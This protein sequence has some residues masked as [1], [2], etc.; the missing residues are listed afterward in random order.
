MAKVA[1]KYYTVAPWAII[2]EGFDP[3]RGEVSE[4]IFSLSNE[5][6]GVR[7]YFEEGYSGKALIGSYF[8]GI[9][10]ETGTG[11]SSYYRGLALTA[12][13]MVNSVDW[14]YTRIRIDEE[15][16]D[17][18]KCNIASFVRKLDLKTGTLNREYIW[19]TKSGKSIK[20]TFQRF[21][22][23]TAQNIGCQ[24]IVFEPLNFTGEIE[25][26]SG[27]DFTPG[28]MTVEGRNFW[29][30][31]KKVTQGNRAAI[32][33]ETV[34]TGQHVFS[35]FYLHSSEAITPQPVEDEKYVGLKFTLAVVEG[36]KISVEKIIFNHADKSLNADAEE[37][38]DMGMRLSS[39]IEN[40]NFDRALIAHSEYWSKVWDTLDIT[41]EGDEE[42]QQGIRYCIFQLHQTYHGQDASNNVG[43]KGLTGEVYSGHTFWDTETYCLP[44]Y[45]F[46][47][48]VAARNLLGYRYKTLPQAIEWAKLQ[49]CEGAQYP[50]STIDGTESCGTWW[51]G[52]L[53]IHVSAAVSYGIWNYVHVTGDKAFLFEQGIEMLIQ[54]SRFFYSRGNWAPQ[55]GFGLYGVMGAD[56]YHTM[57]SNNCYTNVMAK[58]TFEY[59]LRAIADM[60][61]A[62]PERLQELFKKVLMKAEEQQNWHDAAEKMII[63][64]DKKTGL[65]EQHNGFFGLPHIDVDAIPTNQFPLIKHWAMPRIYRYDMIKQPDVLLFLFFYSQDYTIGEKRANYEYYEPKCI[66]ESSLSPSI[67]SIIASEIGEHEQARDFSL[68]STRLDLDNYNRNT[69][70]GLHTTSIAAAWMNIVYGF[71]GMRSDG[72]MLVFNPSIP[73]MWNGFSF[74]VLYRGATIKVQVTKERAE[75]S[76]ISGPELQVKIFNAIY[77]VGGETLC[78][79]LPDDRKG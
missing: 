54:I 61:Q 36:N 34:K 69:S 73:S 41:I 55:G 21:A 10:E 11:N 7:G 23:M 9:L 19:T 48:P 62:E 6:M 16:L 70:E 43:A 25:V 4:S 49:D 60:Q 35:S 63:L 14:L 56:E 58:K 38:W 26:L 37:V 30:C 5:Y 28:H 24:R 33:G 3:S 64:F 53:E 42:N 22:S 32:L 1:D 45:L 17:I 66:H 79:M 8:N 13:F 52:N 40:L 68:Y 75:F 77:T 18:A 50:M 20:L 67:H 74:R 46:N 44:F 31:P 2:E 59:T 51:H 57:V 27:L 47:N 65:Y 15:A 72:E 71:G 29:N 12:R 39:E 76:V 78:I